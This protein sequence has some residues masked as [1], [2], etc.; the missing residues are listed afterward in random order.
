MTLKTTPYYCKVKFNNR[1]F[2][3]RLYPTEENKKN[4][5]VELETNG[6]L[7]GED[8]T[9]LKNYLQQEGY[10]DEAYEYYNS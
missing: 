4:F 5:S 9:A 7:S 2:K 8:Y 1:T 6:W 3:V 10:M